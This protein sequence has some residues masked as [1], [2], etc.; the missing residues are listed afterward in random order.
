MLRSK[1]Q[2]ITVFIKIAVKDLVKTVGKKLGK[3]I[4]IYLSLYIAFILIEKFIGYTPIGF[5]LLA[6]IAF[7]FIGRILFTLGI[8][9][10]GGQYRSLF[11]DEKEKLLTEILEEVKKK[12]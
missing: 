11:P 6:I 8:I 4:A 9:L 2:Y 5:V 12:K 3:E 1:L 10:N 7:A